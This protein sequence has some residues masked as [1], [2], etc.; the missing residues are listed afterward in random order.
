MFV[1]KINY[2]AEKNPLEINKN[3]ENTELLTIKVKNETQLKGLLDED[4]YDAFVKNIEDQKLSEAVKTNS[5]G[6]FFSSKKNSNENENT[7]KSGQEDAS[8]VSATATS[9]KA[10]SETSKA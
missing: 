7:N 8:P 3:P 9:S 5:I 4:E 2:E 10:P 6:G 1:H